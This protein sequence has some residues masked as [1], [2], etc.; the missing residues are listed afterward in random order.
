MIGRRG[1]NPPGLV[2]GAGRGPNPSG[3]VGGVGMG[4][5]P[6]PVGGVGRRNGVGLLRWQMIDTKPH[7]RP[8]LSSCCLSPSWAW[9]AP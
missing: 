5:P 7:R 4:N 2:G 3:P 6:G 1:P 8:T 9:S